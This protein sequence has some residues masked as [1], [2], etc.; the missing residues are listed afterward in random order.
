MKKRTPILVILV[1]GLMLNACSSITI[2][3]SW[4]DEN[5]RLSHENKVL[6][7]AR[8]DDEMARKAFEDEISKELNKDKFKAHKSYITLPKLDPNKKLT[9]NE[10]DSIKQLLNSNGYDGVV[11]SVVKDSKVDTITTREG[12]YYIGDLGHF[13]YPF[14]YHGFYDYY[15]NPYS[16]STYGAYIPEI[17]STEISKTYILETTVYNLNNNDKKQL[18]GVVSSEIINPG[19]LQKTASQYAKAIVKQLK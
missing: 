6:V 7:V 4:V 3:D 8:T 17:Y 1:L 10:K 12:G 9:P 13:Y 18:V 14:Y 16:Y 11:L 2:L 15:F 19:L 5:N